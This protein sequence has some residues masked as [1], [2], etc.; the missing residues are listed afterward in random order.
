[1][2]EA[3]TTVL[4]IVGF[5]AAAHPSGVGLLVIKHLPGTA[6]VGATQAQIDRETES[7]QYGIRAEQCTQLARVLLELADKLHAARSALN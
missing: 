2:V 5:D 7:R 6:P 1:M 4:P 3:M